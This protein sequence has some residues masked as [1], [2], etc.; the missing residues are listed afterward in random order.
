MPGTRNGTDLRY[1]MLT[2]ERT[3]RDPANKVV[4][5]LETGTVQFRKDCSHP[6]CSSI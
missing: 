3:A 1:P 5:F 6:T 2:D 4:T